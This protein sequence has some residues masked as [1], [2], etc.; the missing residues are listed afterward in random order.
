MNDWGREV[1]VT[2]F[3]VPGEGFVRIK[4]E[5]RKSMARDS[6]LDDL[7]DRMIPRARIQDVR[8]KEVEKI[9]V[10]NFQSSIFNFY[11][12]FWNATTTRLSC[13]DKQPT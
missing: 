3:L 9:A 8:I 6:R 13:V 4:S 2:A 1:G 12:I 5:R 10:F 7:D 11:F